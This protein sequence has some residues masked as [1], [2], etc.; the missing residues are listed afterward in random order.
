MA[1]DITPALLARF[2]AKVD[3]SGDCWL[4]TGSKRTGYGQIGIGG[5]A[6]RPM[7]AHRVSY[8]IAYGAIPEGLFVCHKCDV[9]AYVNPA[10]L[11]LGTN[12]D[13]LKDSVAKG[14]YMA[15][16]RNPVWT[17]PEKHAHGQGHANAKL[18]DEQVIEIRR[19]YACKEANQR[20]LAERFGVGQ[21]LVSDIVRGK[22]WKHLVTP[23]E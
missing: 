15:D 10:H 14:H 3:K 13:N 19:A 17:H 21:Q 9:R 8:E 12:S 20:Q 1:I 6:G 11:F 22:R 5:R 23:P 4:W 2:W 18:T 7:P 16:G